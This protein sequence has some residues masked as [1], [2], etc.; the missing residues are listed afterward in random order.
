MNRRRR[1]LSLATVAALILGSLTACGDNPVQPSSPGPPFA[2][3]AP[4]NT[5]T[6]SG[7]VWVYSDKGLNPAPA[8]TTFGWLQFSNGG[9]T[10]GP[11]PVGATGRYSFPIPKETVLVRVNPSSPGY[12]PCAET[13]EPR[14]DVVIDSY[15]VTDT[16]QLGTNLPAALA[17]RLPL[18]SGVLYEQTANG[19]RPVPNFWVTLDAFGGDGMMVADTLTD[20][21]GRYVFCNVPHRPGL[22][23]ATGGG[24]FDLAYADALNKTKV[25]VELKRK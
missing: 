14:G 21:E 10:T 11:V 24:V 13:I 25:D 17:S 7:T 23:I 4:E 22:V 6:V 12:Q 1:V 5:W 8:G 16:T 20:A 3:P 9:R 15:H 19:P 2:P 18:V